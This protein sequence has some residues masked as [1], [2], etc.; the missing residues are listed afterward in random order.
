VNAT[1][2]SITLDLGSVAFTARE[3]LLARAGAL[4]ITTF[5]YRSGVSGLRLSGRRGEIIILPF[6]GQQVWDAHIDGRRLTMRS[7]FDEPLQ[8]VEYTRNYGGFLV[9][10]GLSGLG[11]P[12]SEDRHPVHGDLP[13]AAYDQAH[14]TIGQDESGYFADVSGCYHHRDAFSANYQ[15]IPALRFRENSGRLEMRITIRNLR[16]KPL[17]YLYCGHI[18]FRPIDGARILDSVPDTPSRARVH[19]RRSEIGT[20]SEDHQTLIEALS[21]NPGPHRDVGRLPR[22]DPSVSLWLTPDAGED[23]WS[24]AMQLLSDGSADFVSF[25]PGDFDHCSRWMVRNG[26]EEALGLVLPAT[27]EADGFT[28]ELAKGNVRWLAPQHEFTA[29]YAF[30]A[31][32]HAEAAS[33]Q[34][35]IELAGQL[36]E[37][38]DEIREN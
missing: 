22:I 9:H 3:S 13:H 6:H 2:P 20:W 12:R 15:F 35:Q 38:V 31:L 14:I 33:M 21:L 30:G 29:T 25:R 28:A 5:Q 11:A 16:S 1:E 26:D 32:D 24:H 27:A 4:S 10:C 7:I 34:E 23:G 17:S 37:R 18:N 19:L 36:Q 8:Y